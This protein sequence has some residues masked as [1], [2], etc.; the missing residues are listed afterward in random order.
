M[1]KMKS[2]EKRLRRS[3][4]DIILVFNDPVFALIFALAFVTFVDA[5]SI[6]DDWD[7]YRRMAMNAPVSAWRLHFLLD[8]NFSIL[9]ISGA[10]AIASL[11]LLCINMRLLSPN[12]TLPEDAVQSAQIIMEENPE[13][14]DIL[15]SLIQE[16]TEMD[17]GNILAEKNQEIKNF[18]RLK[19]RL[20]IEEEELTKLRE[21]I[22]RE[23][24][25]L[26]SKSK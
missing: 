15:E 8:H 23:A 21:E 5:L 2:W 1:K 4:P 17:D 22:I 26:R 9:L 13:F 16:A 24:M 12:R 11:T 6:A 20:G 7:G 19:E 3:I 18:L 14:S 10:L 25:K